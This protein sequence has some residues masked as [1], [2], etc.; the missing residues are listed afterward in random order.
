MPLLNLQDE[1]F[2]FRVTVDETSTDMYAVVD[3]SLGYTVIETTGCT[4]CGQGGT[5]SAFDTTSG[6]AGFVVGSTNVSGRLN[7]PSTT[8]SGKDGTAT[9]CIIAYDDSNVATAPTTANISTLPCMQLANV[10]FADTVAT[11]ND[12]AT[13]YVGAALANGVDFYGDQPAATDNVLV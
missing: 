2:T 5:S 7:N 3:T 1:T 9:F 13:V 6:N 8:Y 11:A 10:R 4:N 12:D